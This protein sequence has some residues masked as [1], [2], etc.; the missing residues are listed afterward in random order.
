MIDLRS[1]RTFFTDFVKIQKYVT[2]VLRI[3]CFSK[4]L[5]LIFIK[6]IDFPQQDI[7]D[8]N[9]KSPHIL[10]NGVLNQILP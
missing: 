3:L 6:D 7:L 10:K 9:T 8:I 2:V 1:L 4:V 5:Q